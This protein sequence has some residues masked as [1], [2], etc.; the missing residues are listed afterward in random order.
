MNN[1]CTFILQLLS[2]RLRLIEL[3]QLRLLELNV[4]VRI[5]A[6]VLMWLMYKMF[7]LTWISKD[8]LFIEREVFKPHDSCI[9]FISY[10]FHVIF[11]VV[12]FLFLLVSYSLHLNA[13]FLHVYW[14]ANIYY[15]KHISTTNIRSKNMHTETERDRSYLQHESHLL[16]AHIFSASLYCRR[17]IGWI[18]Y[19]SFSS[20]I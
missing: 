8:V 11:L 2:D 1:Y 12:L 16:S 15:S 20:F 10:L 13:M 14:I 17:R 5:F 18:V 4:F 19:S 7:P 3:K 9:N 6:N